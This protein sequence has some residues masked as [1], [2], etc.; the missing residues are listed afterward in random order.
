LVE[1]SARTL[2]GRFLL[3][4]VPEVNEIILGVL[5]RAQAK[6]GVVIHLF[7]FLSNHYHMLLSV[8]NAKQLSRFMAFVDANIAKEVGRLV[9][10][11]GRFWG[12]RYHCA[13][14]NG[15]EATLIERMRYILSN[16]CKEGLVSSPLQWGGVSAAR[17]ICEG[18]ESLE[19]VWYDRTAEYRARLRGEAHR[20]PSI[21]TVHLS[22]IPCW[23]DL[24]QE[25]QQIRT[26]E[27]VRDIERDAD[28][29]HRERNSKPMG[30][31][32][33]RRQNPHDKPKNFRPSPAPL[34][35]AATREGRRQ[36][37]EAFRLF[38]AAY[39]LAAEQLRAGN[40]GVRFPAGSFPPPR[41]F[42]ETFAPG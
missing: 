12:R 29:M 18:R 39:R 16:S 19:G 26:L 42:V 22:P 2:Q 7:V 31:K 21:E 4:P 40:V 32:A 38:V 8:Q 20:F 15:D 28:S 3:R 10:W 14:V 27:L 33:V 30:M 36:L 5:G 34:F 11:Q 41:P 23:A 6:Y 13:L 37:R 25:Q 17:A 35:H 1:V 24:D 9:G